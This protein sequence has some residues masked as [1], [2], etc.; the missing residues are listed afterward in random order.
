MTLNLAKTIA[1]FLLSKQNISRIMSNPP[2][3]V[4][5]GESIRISKQ[6]KLLGLTLTIE[7]YSINISVK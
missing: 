5:N 4:L 6:E 3:T 1:M 2:N 7:D